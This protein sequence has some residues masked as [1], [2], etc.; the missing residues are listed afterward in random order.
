M[1]SISPTQTLE[2]S[3]GIDF[4]KN[5]LDKHISLCNKN[6][7]LEIIFGKLTS[8]NIFNTNIYTEHNIKSLIKSIHKLEETDS[9]FKINISSNNLKRFF[10]DNSIIEAQVKNDNQTIISHFSKNIQHLENIEDTK[11]DYQLI[12]IE[13][14]NDTTIINSPYFNHSEELE[15]LEITFN[16][17]FSIIIEKSLGYLCKIQI[18]KPINTQFIIDILKLF[19]TSSYN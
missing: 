10:Y 17:S 5:N 15:L 4:L 9:K 12:K 13:F 19:P 18:F 8:P 6:N 1:E 2:K 7:V 3:S 14:Y 16:N 11:L